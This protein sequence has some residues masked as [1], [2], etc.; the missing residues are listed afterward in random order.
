VRAE[1]RSEREEEAADRPRR[2]DGET[3]EHETVPR[4]R[5]HGGP[6]D[7]KPEATRAFDRLG[8]QVDAH[9]RKRKER[10]STAYGSTRVA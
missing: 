1:L 10:K 8:H 4:D 2:Q 6:L 7:R 3:G 9:E 5:G